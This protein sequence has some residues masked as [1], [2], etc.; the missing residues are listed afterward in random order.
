MIRLPIGDIIRDSFKLA[1]KFKYLWL[2]GFFAGAGGGF[3]VPTGQWTPE[4]I[5]AAKEW[6]VAALAM[7]IVV[8]G[9]VMLVMMVMHVICKSAL[10]Y[11]VYQI[12]TDGAHSLSAGWEFGLKRFWPMLGLLLLEAVIAMAF[13]FALI[14]IEVVIFAIAVPLGFLSL[15]IAIP[16]GILGLVAL[17]LTWGY[18]ERFVTLEMRGVIDS[19]GE[20]WT[21]LR[22]QWQPSIMMGL[23]K[24]GITIALAIAMMGIGALLLAPAVALWFASKPLAIVYGVAIGL[25]YLVLLSAYFGTFDYAVWTKVFLHLRA[26]VYAAAQGDAPPPQTPPSPESTRTPP[27]I[28]E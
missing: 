1:W 5:E 20:G 25:P 10:I 2:L 4:R 14:L 19:I 8:G 12:H 26:P 21:L 13:V 28:F 15:L 17:I 7:L 23:V 3:N 18:A 24:F 11:N 16:A 9:F 6:L 27:P 22:Q